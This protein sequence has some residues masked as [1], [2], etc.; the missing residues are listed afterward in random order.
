MQ[1]LPEPQLG[2]I[3]VIAKELGTEP[4]R[5]AYVIRTR[6]IRPSARAGRLRLFNADA[7]ARVDRE[8]RSMAERQ[9]TSGGVSR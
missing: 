8:L 1:S 5:V 4:H 3:G 9:G 6:G 7:I 2:T